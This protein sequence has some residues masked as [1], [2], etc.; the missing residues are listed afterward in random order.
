MRIVP[1]GHH[2]N[3]RGRELYSGLTTCKDIGVNLSRHESDHGVKAMHLRSVN[4]ITFPNFTCSLS[5]INQ[6]QKRKYS[7][8]RPGCLRCTGCRSVFS[9]DSFSTPT[10][11]EG[12][13]LRPG[14]PRW[15]EGA[16]D[17]A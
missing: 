15:R 1:D 14:M 3:N 8:R 7:C 6:L 10:S 17:A 5:V 9:A 16:E 13:L 11:R 12:S 2:E 4:N